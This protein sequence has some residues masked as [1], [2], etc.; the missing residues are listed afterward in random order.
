MKWNTKQKNSFVT[1]LALFSGA[2]AMFV[3]TL[4]DRSYQ[5]ILVMVFVVILLIGFDK[6]NDWANKELWEIEK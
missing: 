1:S 6:L 4:V 3:L 5:G 2:L